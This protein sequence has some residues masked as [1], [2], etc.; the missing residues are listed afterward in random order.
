MSKLFF[1]F[2]D[3]YF[4]QAGIPLEIRKLNLALVARTLA[5]EP[6]DITPGT[7]HVTAMLPTGQKLSAQVEVIQGVDVTAILGY[8][9]DTGSPDMLKT[10]AFSPHDIF[11]SHAHPEPKSTPNRMATRLRAF[12]YNELSNNYELVANQQWFEQMDHGPSSDFDTVQIRVLT[13][14]AH[15]VQFLQPNARVTNILLPTPQTCQLIV[16]W[17]PN[18]QCSLIVQ[19]QNMWADML[20]QYSIR[21]L[22]DQA[23]TMIT[24]RLLSIESLFSQEGSDPIAA[25]IVAYFLLRSG[26]FDQLRMWTENLFTQFQWLSDSVIIRSEYLARVGEHDEALDTLLRIES[27]RLPIFSDGLL[28]AV[29]RLRLYVNTSDSY[30]N[31][32]R[33]VKAQAILNHLEQHISFVDFSNP[34]L[35]FTGINPNQPSNETAREEL[36]RYGGVDITYGLQT[37]IP[38]AG[39]DEERPDSTFSQPL[40]SSRDTKAVNETQSVQVLVVDDEIAMV[41]LL[42]DMLSDVGY[43]VARAHDGR[44]ALALLRAGLRPRIVITD[45]MMPNLDGVGLYRAIR[46]EFAEDHIVVLIMSAG[47]TVNL[48]DP[49]ASFMTKPFSIIDLL[50]AIERFA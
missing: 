33:I 45:L 44:S 10:E 12:R 42:A 4:S 1:D 37:L 31:N 36:S 8:E 30:F 38:D 43:E 22:F 49:E 11:H 13:D 16:T 17:F 46:T 29:D 2:E 7:Y 23:T 9:E 14:K 50:D 28:Y 24:S 6:I 3:K 32:E 41:D 27:D 25:T 20:L 34:L 18:R 26:D 21:G 35:T 48:G 15:L 5:S 39:F 19:F 40:P 47:K